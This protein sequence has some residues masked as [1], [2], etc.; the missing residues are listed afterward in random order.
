M[1]AIEHH[2]RAA[3]LHI[4]RE[5]A[6]PDLKARPPRLREPLDPDLVNA[7]LRLL[8]SR[9][10]TAGMFGRRDKAL[11][12]LAA[13]TDLPYRELAVMR[14]GQLEVTDGVAGVTDTAGELHLIEANSDSVLCGPCALIRWRRIIDTEVRG[15]SAQGMADLF[16][17]APQITAAS[18]HPCHAP[19]PIRDKTLPVPLFPPIN[20]WGHLPS[21]INPMTRRAT[22]TLARQIH[23]GI[24]A[25]RDLNLDAVID[26]TNPPSVAAQV[27]ADTAPRPVYDWAT[28]NQKKK[29]AVAQLASLSAT[30]DEMDTRINALLER[31]RNLELD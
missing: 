8:P 30:M 5:A 31:T 2:H 19:K 9:G 4:T 27:Q 22:S 14:V 28:A 24:P 10:W 29:D 25:H 23:T 12:V 17:N 21:P 11:L 6:D 13:S 20:Q 15:T 26:V 3:G 1:A 18:R 16:R 7:A